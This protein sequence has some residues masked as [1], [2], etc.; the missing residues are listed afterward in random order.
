MAVGRTHGE[1]LEQ[2]RRRVRL[3]LIA[4][5]LA[6]TA[7]VLVVLL[8]PERREHVAGHAYAIPALRRRVVVEVL[9]GTGRPGVARLATRT[10]RARGFDV[11]FFGN[12]GSAADTTRILVRRGDPGR[13]RDVRDALGSGRIAVD[14][15]TTRRV[16]VSVLLGADY[17]FTGELHP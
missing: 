4:A 8:L 13:G 3:A 5:A 11:V 6:T 12:A 10:L 17:R 2:P 9:N 15:D 16:D 7:G 14:P 1:L